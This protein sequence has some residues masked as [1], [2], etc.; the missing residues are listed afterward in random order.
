MWGCSRRVADCDLDHAVPY[1]A[2]PTAGANLSGLCRHHHRVK[3]APGWRHTLHADGTTEW[4][5][6]G[7]TQRVT[8]PTAHAAAVPDHPAWRPSSLHAGPPIGP[9]AMEPSGDLVD[10][11]TEGAVTEG[12]D[13]G[14][15]PF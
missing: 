15:P 13:V 7:G 2:G 14:S 12:A 4:T 11:G 9:I 1:P 10:A 6:P 8:W 3:H 5:S